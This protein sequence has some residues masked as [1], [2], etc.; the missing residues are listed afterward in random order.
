MIKIYNEQKFKSR[1]DILGDY[2]AELIK[3]L[4]A[5]KKMSTQNLMKH[6]HLVFMTRFM[7]LKI[8]V[9]TSY[10]TQEEFYTLEEPKIFIKDLLNTHG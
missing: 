2:R 10:T 4:K 3:R 8:Q 1:K 7:H 6:Y 9:F 5:A